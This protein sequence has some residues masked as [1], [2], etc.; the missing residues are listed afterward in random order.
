M[1][2]SSSN[3]SPYAIPACS[4]GI[5]R[6]PQEEGDSFLAFAEVRRIED[7][8]PNQSVELDLYQGPGEGAEDVLAELRTL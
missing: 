1:T 2:S 8:P 5:S 6:L 4:S 7:L 3:G